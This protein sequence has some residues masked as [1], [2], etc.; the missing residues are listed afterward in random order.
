VE[1]YLARALSRAGD[2]SSTSVELEK[3]IRDWPSEYHLSPKRSQLLRPFQFERASSVLEVGCGCGAITRFLGETFDDVVAVE[4]SLTRARLARM[5]TRDMSNVSV[6]CAPFQ[7]LRFKSAF[8]IVFCIGVLE[9]AG[10]FVL[11]EDPFDTA[12]AFLAGPSAAY[13][14]GQVLRVNGGL[15]M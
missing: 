3:S 13:V 4:G 10:R 5:R 7:E 6:V 1:G 8:D 2:L 11:A 9:Y 15:F 14:T 12:V